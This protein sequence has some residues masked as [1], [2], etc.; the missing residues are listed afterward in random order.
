MRDRRGLNYDAPGSDL[1]VR[2]QSDTIGFT[3]I[4]WFYLTGAAIL[5]GGEVNSEIERAAAAAGEKDARLPGEKSPGEKGPG[6][7]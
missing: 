3:T 7:N 5:I 2:Q 4:L 1:V 6:E